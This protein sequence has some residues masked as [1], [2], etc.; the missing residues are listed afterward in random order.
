MLFKI[1]I[2]NKIQVF[3]RSSKN[4]HQ[5]MP[6]NYDYHRYKLDARNTFQIQFGRFRM[7]KL[8]HIPNQRKTEDYVPFHADT[9]RF[10]PLDAVND[11]SLPLPYVPI[12]ETC[13]Q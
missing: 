3:Q 2:R 13:S 6:I 10:R 5:T 1:Y 4:K 8:P 7:Q 12:V 11:A 9:V